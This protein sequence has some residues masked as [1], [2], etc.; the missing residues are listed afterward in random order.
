MQVRGKLYELLAN[1]IPPELIIKKLLM[2]LLKKL[3]DDVKQVGPGAENGDSH[4]PAVWGFIGGGVASRAPQTKNAGSMSLLVSKHVLCEV[5][6]SVG[7][8]SIN[9][10]KSE[11]MGSKVACRLAS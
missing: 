8:L 6:F 3:D 2:E 9:G 4:L 1:C 7:R 11:D 5:W 10:C